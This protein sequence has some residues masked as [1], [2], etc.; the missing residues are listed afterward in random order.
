[1]KPALGPMVILVASRPPESNR[2][3]R[4]QIDGSHVGSGGYQ[5]SSTS[6]HLYLRER[7]GRSGLVLRISERSCGPA[8]RSIGLIWAADVYVT[9][10]ASIL[11]RDVQIRF[12]G[13]VE[14]HFHRVSPARRGK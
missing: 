14:R 2:G 6:P 3:Y 5:A 1:M 12:G 11:Y 13:E 9:Y 7:G 8:R 4:V 10:C